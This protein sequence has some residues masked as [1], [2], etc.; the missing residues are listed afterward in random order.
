VASEGP[1]SA[2]TLVVLAVIAYFAS[3]DF[4]PDA[5]TEAETGAFTDSKTISKTLA[6]LLFLGVAVVVLDG[7]SSLLRLVGSAPLPVLLP[8]LIPAL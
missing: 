6:I 2:R 7:F 1:T 4:S 5:S 8:F 3:P